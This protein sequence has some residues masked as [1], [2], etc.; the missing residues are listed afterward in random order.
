[1]DRYQPASCASAAKRC[2]ERSAIRSAATFSAKER[3]AASSKI[4]GRLDVPTL[5]WTRGMS[6][7]V[8]ITARVSRAPVDEQH[9]C[10]AITHDMSDPHTTWRKR[11]RIYRSF[12]FL[13]DWTNLAGSAVGRREVLRGCLPGGAL[14]FSRASGTTEATSRCI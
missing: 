9:C 6:S 8:A 10:D 14:L 12:A 11:L 4:N 2:V 3:Y 5:Y 13:D 1:M 7:S